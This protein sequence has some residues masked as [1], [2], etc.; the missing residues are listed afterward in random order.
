MTT[1]LIRFGEF[2][3]SL[4]TNTRNTK[5]GM[6]LDELKAQNAAEELA[7]ND[8]PVVDTKED[9]KDEYVEVVDD[10]KADDTKELSQDS[11]DTK[12]ELE[13]WQLTEESVDSD[14]DKKEG[15]V[16]NHEA[17]RR[18]KKAK[19]LSVEL[20]GEQDEN[21]A[22]R[23]QI[24]D[25]Q[26]GSTPK[27]QEEA[28]ALVRPTREQFDYDDDAFDVAIEAYHD[29]RLER[30][31]NARDNKTQKS[32]DDSA[33]QKAF[34]EQAAKSFDNH[35]SGA[36]ELIDS[37]KITEDSFRGS[38]KLVKEAL[39][40]ANPGRGEIAFNTLIVGLGK[41]SAKVEFQLG[42]NPA[43]LH[44]LQSIQAADPSG[45]SASRF[46]GR[47]QEKIQT[48]SK[49]R[50][51]APKPGAVITGDG[52]GGGKHA[53]LLAEYKKSDDMKTRMMLKRKARSQ[54]ADTSNW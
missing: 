38:E 17:A 43:L 37:G 24:E 18:R 29:E 22:L 52:S 35:Y 8:A 14:D 16:P 12:V 2:N 26:N 4:V 41:D 19:A 53:P 39:E 33:R 21:A 30:K 5:M 34:Q 27:A 7:A 11:D 31:L 10:A 3:R 36:Q 46:L 28:K 42:V 9:I 48:P 47:L 50:S 45:L 1:H 54:G 15:F 25:L 23:K 44:E 51:N 20:K 13:S 6:T 49:K 40:A 32:T